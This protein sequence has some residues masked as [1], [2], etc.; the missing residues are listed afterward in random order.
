MSINLSINVKYN[1]I[2]LLSALGLGILLTL[3]KLLQFIVYFLLLFCDF[4]ATT[5]RQLLNATS[6]QVA[7]N[8]ALSQTK[9]R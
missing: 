4:I 9:C 3:A 7:H 1:Y 6:Q 2:Y 5:I 8:F